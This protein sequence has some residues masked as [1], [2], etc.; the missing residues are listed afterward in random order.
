MELKE[1]CRRNRQK[2]DQAIRS[3]CSNCQIEG[4]DDREDW[5]LNDESLYNWAKSEGVDL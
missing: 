1:F 4:D 5:V 3:V 2:I